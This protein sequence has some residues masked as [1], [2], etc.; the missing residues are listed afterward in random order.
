MH[1]EGLVFLLLAADLLEQVLEGAWYDAS[2]VIAKRVVDA[3]H[4]VRLA[5][6]CLAIGE[7][8]PIETLQDALSQG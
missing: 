4:G 2:L 3:Y 5:S 1:F 8:S 6:A 7:D